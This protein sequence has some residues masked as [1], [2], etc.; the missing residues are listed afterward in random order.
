MFTQSSF[1]HALLQVIVALTA[2]MVAVVSA[3]PQRPAY[4]YGPDYI[5]GFDYRGDH[6]YVRLCNYLHLFC[7]F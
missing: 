5:P 6:Y 1:H 3:A 7:N 2:L 4:G